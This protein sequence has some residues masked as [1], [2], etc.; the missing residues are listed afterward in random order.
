M[1]T[2]VRQ[3]AESVLL[4]GSIIPHAPKY[5]VIAIVPVIERAVDTADGGGG[6]S[7]FLRNFQICFMAF[8]HS[9][10]FKTLGKG[11]QVVYCTEILKKT[12]TLFPA[13][14]TENGIKQRIHCFISYLFIHFKHLTNY[15]CTVKLYSSTISILPY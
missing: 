1:P 4:F 9:G 10:H 15:F 6:S 7:G 13:L 5:H 2:F 3:Y 8:Q 12:V 11:E 14:Q